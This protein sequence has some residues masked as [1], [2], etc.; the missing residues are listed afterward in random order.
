MFK[1]GSLVKIIDSDEC[2]KEFIGKFGIVLEPFFSYYCVKI[3]ERNIYLNLL[4]EEIELVFEK[5]NYNRRVCYICGTK[6]KKTKCKYVISYCPK[7]L[8]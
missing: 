3:I 5:T 1:I 2:Y 4:P 7:C 8:M 6:L